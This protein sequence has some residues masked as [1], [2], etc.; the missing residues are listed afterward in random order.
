MPA[1]GARS[2]SKKKAGKSKGK[3]GAQKARKASRHESF[4]TYIFK[5]MKNA[6]AAVSEKSMKKSTMAALDS[7]CRDLFERIASEAG[8]LAKYS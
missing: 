8:S 4:A 6:D 5:T 2:A 3:M 1:K 7:I